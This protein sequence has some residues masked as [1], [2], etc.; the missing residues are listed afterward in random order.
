MAR[1]GAVRKSGEAE[2]KGERVGLWEGRGSPS[3][4]YLQGWGLGEQGSQRVTAA[5]T[6]IGAEGWLLEQGVCGWEV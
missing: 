4:L 5:S 6:P 3:F 1:T 2:G